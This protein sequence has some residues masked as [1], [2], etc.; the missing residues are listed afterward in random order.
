MVGGLGVV[1]RMTL[2]Q[3]MFAIPIALGATAIAV[4]PLLAISTKAASDPPH[5]G[6]YPTF[7]PRP[8]QCVYIVARLRRDG[9]NELAVLAGRLR[10][11]SHLHSRKAASDIGRHVDGRQRYLVRTRDCS[12]LLGT[13]K[14][15]AATASNATMRAASMN[16]QSSRKCEIAAN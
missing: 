11:T 2:R 4:A 12:R 8:F 16:K 15:P 5:R 9:A 14:I 7:V 6:N 1:A 3:S 13:A 10:R